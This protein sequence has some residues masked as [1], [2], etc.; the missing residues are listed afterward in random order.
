MVVVQDVGSPLPKILI[1]RITRS[2]RIRKQIL[3]IEIIDNRAKT[4]EIKLKYGDLNS[5]IN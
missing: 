3:A 2:E 4:N 1:L 5:Y